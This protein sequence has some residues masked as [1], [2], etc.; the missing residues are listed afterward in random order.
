[1]ETAIF[2]FVFSNKNIYI[3]GEGMQLPAVEGLEYLASKPCEIF[4]TAKSIPQSL[5][6]STLVTMEMLKALRS[7]CVLCLVSVCV[8]VCL[9]YVCALC[10]CL[11]VRLVSVS[12]C[13][14][15]V[16]V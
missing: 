15:C 11:C 8:C 6:L 9:V 1:M 13:M 5:A 4:T 10:L 14:S 16:C 2:F 12:V 3:K 7:V